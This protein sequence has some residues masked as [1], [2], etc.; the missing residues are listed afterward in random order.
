M[1]TH[2]EFE[3][4][5]I[6]IGGLYNWKDKIETNPKM[7]GVGEGWY[8]LIKNLIDELISLGWDRKLIQSKEKFGGLNFH[9]NESTKEMRELIYTYEKLSYDICEVCGNKGEPR[10]GGWIRTLCDVHHELRK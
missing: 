5:L 2:E 10:K 9:I 1:I 3:E 4:Y 8:E 7:F 6:S